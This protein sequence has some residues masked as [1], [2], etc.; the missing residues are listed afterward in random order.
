ML[1]L[2]CGDREWKDKELICDTLS[3][4]KA[5]YSVTKVI[6]GGARGADFYG[7]SAANTL[8]IPVET[9]KAEWGKF[10]KSAGPIRNRKMLDMQPRLVVA[11]HDAIETSKG[12]K[13]CLKEA[14]RRGIEIW[15]VTHDKLHAPYLGAL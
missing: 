4:I 3:D 13:D 6:E 1:V 5:K 2:I 10:K 7:F 12:T 14:R 11:F 15:L 9:I 8:K